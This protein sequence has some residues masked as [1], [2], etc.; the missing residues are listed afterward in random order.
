VTA[1]NFLRDPLH[2]GLEKALQLRLPPRWYPA[3]IAGALVALTTVA[4]GAVES[5]R[6]QSAE[7]SLRRAEAR[8]ENSRRSL[9]QE[10]LQWDRVD[11]LVAEDRRLRV[12]RV[13]GPVAASKIA[14]AGNALPDGAWLTT[15]TTGSGGLDA[16]GEAGGLAALQSALENLSA[17]P[18]M[19]A[20]ERV[21][22]SADRHVPGRV[23]FEWHLDPRR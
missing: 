5:Y 10:R 21:R 3:A 16:K 18:R 13:S 19:G 7:L 11:R 6:L 20:V 22:F 4:A 17:D 2:P 1:F 8:F 12:L 9:L 14:A 23:A 15:M